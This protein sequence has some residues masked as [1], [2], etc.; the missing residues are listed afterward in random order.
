M[1][2]C[3]LADKDSHHPDALLPAIPSLPTP[4]ATNVVGFFG[5]TTSGTCLTLTFSSL[6]KLS[7]VCAFGESE[8]ELYWC[9]V[10][11]GL[12]ILCG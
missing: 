1:R 3:G 7:G 10:R 5:L 11:H 6:S 4:P 9:E 8:S 2:A 12:E